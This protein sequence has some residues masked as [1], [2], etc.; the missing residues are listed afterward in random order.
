MRVWQILHIWL[1]FTIRLRWVWVCVCVT[2]NVWCLNCLFTGLHL[3]DGLRCWYG[4]AFSDSLVQLTFW[5]KLNRFRQILQYP[6][7]LGDVPADLP[8]GHPHHRCGVWVTEMLCC[9]LPAGCSA[10]IGRTKIIPA[11]LLHWSWSV[12][13]WHPDVANL[14]GKD[15]K[16]SYLVSAS[17]GRS[18]L[19]VRKPH[20]K[21][22]PLCKAPLATCLVKPLW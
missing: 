17:K 16:D 12:A 19:R 21:S 1:A 2:N 5:E 4:W 3:F 13:H 20:G 8:A 14:V 6:A 10:A 9:P 11:I 18:A 22:R 15:P 7:D